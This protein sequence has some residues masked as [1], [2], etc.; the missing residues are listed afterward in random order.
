MRQFKVIVEFHSLGLR[1][2]TLSVSTADERV[3]KQSVG[4]PSFCFVLGK[5]RQDERFS[6]VASASWCRIKWKAV[7]DDLG[8]DVRTGQ[9]VP[10]WFAG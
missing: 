6:R 7:T 10:R 3:G 9:L 1:S 2:Q 8:N 4:W 5:T